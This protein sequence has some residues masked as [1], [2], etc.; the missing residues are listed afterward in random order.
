[1]QKE[2]VGNLSRFVNQN[3][4]RN[5]AVAYSQEAAGSE[6]EAQMQAMGDALGKLRVRL[7]VPDGEWGGARLSESDLAEYE[8][9]VDQFSQSF[10]RPYGPIWRH[11]MLLDVS[12]EKL[13]GLREVFEVR[14]VSARRSV[15]GQVLSLV[16][17]FVLICAVYLFLNAAT[18]GY[19]TWALRIALLGLFLLAVFLIRLMF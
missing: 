13:E 7:A 8:I 5:Y 9:V 11:A 4:G 15:G 14:Q 10:A 1:M 3:E 6:Y 16:G 17:I 2:W 12:P 18:R 19:Y